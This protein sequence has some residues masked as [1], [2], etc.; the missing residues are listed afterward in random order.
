MYIQRISMYEGGLGEVIYGI[1]AEFGKNNSICTGIELAAHGLI[2]SL[3]TF[4][5]AENV[6][7][8]IYM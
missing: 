5:D 1:S 4:F 6:R 8:L 7:S 2:D 3:S